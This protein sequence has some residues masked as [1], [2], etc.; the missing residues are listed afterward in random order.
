MSIQRDPIS[1]AD[2]PFFTPDVLVVLII[3]GDTKIF[4]GDG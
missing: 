1:R 4:T 3:A 2:A